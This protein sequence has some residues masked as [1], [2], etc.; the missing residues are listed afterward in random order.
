MEKKQ[1]NNSLLRWI[2]GKISFA[3]AYT[4]T[5]NKSALP[6]KMQTQKDTHS[7]GSLSILRNQAHTLRSLQ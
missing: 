7:D 2:K 3:R 1:Q 4:N 5:T 6:Q